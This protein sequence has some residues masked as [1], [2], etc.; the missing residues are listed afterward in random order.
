MPI[1]G[2]FDESV[3]ILAISISCLGNASSPK[4]YDDLGF[5][6]SVLVVFASAFSLADP[7]TL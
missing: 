7:F 4:F 6:I 2:S 3:I 1:A 5:C